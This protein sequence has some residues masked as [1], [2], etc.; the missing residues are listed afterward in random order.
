MTLLSGIRVLDLSLQLPGPLC[1]MMMADY[2]ADVVKIDEPEPRVR[3][4]FAAEEP[5]TGP[6]DRYLNRGK[7]SVTVN[8]KSGEGKTIF[9]GLAET[10]DVVVEGFR[11]GVVRRLGID[12]D[13]V[14]AMILAD[15]VVSMRLK[16]VWTR[17]TASLTPMIICC[18][19][20]ANDVSAFLPSICRRLNVLHAE[21]LPSG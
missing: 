12:Y 3:N 14:S 6:V 2:G 5:G 1:T 8:L 4:P 17:R 11:P 13:A 19:T 10:A 9:L 7:R 18:L 16:S 15:L 21:R 20:L